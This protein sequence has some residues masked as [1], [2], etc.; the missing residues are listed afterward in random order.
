[1]IMTVID[2]TTQTDDRDQIRQV[3]RYN[4]ETEDD[5]DDDGDDDDDDNNNN[6]D[7]DD[8]GG[9]YEN[10]QDRV[11]MLFLLL[12][13]CSRYRDLPSLNAGGNNYVRQPDHFEVYATR[14]V[15]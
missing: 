7:D 5:G 2:H 9:D 6:D 10:W 4:S 15:T 8:V 1:M 3:N 14:K 12:Q 11:L 13:T